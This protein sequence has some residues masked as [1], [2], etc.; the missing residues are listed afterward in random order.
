MMCHVWTVS[1]TCAG[2]ATIVLGDYRIDMKQKIEIKHNIKDKHDQ[3]R[4]KR[5]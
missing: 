2:G 3:G 1:T 4:L 5:K